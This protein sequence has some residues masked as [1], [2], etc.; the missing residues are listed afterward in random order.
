MNSNDKALVA[1]PEWLAHRYQAD[2]DL[3]HFRHVSRAAHANAVFATD[4]YLG[5]ADSVRTIHRQ[6]ATG[7]VGERAPLHF[8][9][10]SAFC[11]STLLARAFERPGTT[12]ALKEPYLFN[13]LV[14][15]R[16]R[17]EAQGAAFVERLESALSLLSRP[18]GA[19]EAVIIKPSNVAN[20]L[21]PA[22]MAMRPN[23]RAVLLYAPL[24]TYLKSIVKK[25]IDGRLWVRDL[26]V[27]LISDNIIDLGLAGEDYLRL[28]DIQ[29]AAVG[30]L[31]QHALF[32]RMAA[33]NPDRVRTLDSETLLERPHD[34]LVGLAHL[35]DLELS[36]AEIDAIVAGPAF[37]S[38]SKTGSRF[39]SKDRDAEY[40]Q[41][42]QGHRDELAKVMVWAEAVARNASVAMTLPS[43]L[44]AP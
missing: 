1:D 40:A 9:F 29:A 26:L 18:F 2:L 23:A 38:H 24:A 28:T 32:A 14:G 17:S 43:P 6:Q 37:G 20:A 5:A 27:K 15:V 11:C 30:W 31:A 36:K 39:G 8:I 25:G 16:H 4:E 35:F 7:M 10:H 33:K 42:A 12:M 13:D 41:A 3:I 44:L 19:G 21:A 34:A 22:M